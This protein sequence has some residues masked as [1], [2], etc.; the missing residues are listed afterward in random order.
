MN[1][2]NDQEFRTP[3]GKEYDSAVEKSIRR[4]QRC[5]YSNGTLTTGSRYVIDNMTYRVRS[6]FNVENSKSCEEGLRR[7][8]LQEIDKVS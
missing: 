7:L 3:T 2:F 1:K 6:I 8:M 4:R 5:T